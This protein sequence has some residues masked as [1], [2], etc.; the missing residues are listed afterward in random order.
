MES[1]LEI[2]L[3]DE[4][5]KKL[6]V[7]VLSIVEQYLIFLYSV[8]DE[9]LNSSNNENTCKLKFE[10]IRQDLYDFVRQHSG[11]VLIN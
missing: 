3:S 1:I 11:L 5:T 2:S 8:A 9:Y 4:S 6:K 7:L 10:E